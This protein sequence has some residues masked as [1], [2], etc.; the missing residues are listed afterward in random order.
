M[1][2]GVVNGYAVSN[3]IGVAAAQTIAQEFRA[4]N[5]AIATALQVASGFQ[6]Q[7][8]GIQ[9][10]QRRIAVATAP[11]V[12]AAWIMSQAAQH[13]TSVWAPALG[14]QHQL[15]T[16]FSAHIA[17]YQHAVSIVAQ[18]AQTF[19]PAA[20]LPTWLSDDFRQWLGDILRD[21]RDVADVDDFGL[22]LY[23]AALRARTA[24][25][26]DPDHRRVVELFVRKHL[27]IRRVSVYL[28]DAVCGV[29]LEDEWHES[30]MSEEALRE[31][32][33]RR[34]RQAHQ[35]A[36]PITDARL[37]GQRFVASLDKETTS[38]PAT[39]LV[40]VGQLSLRPY[41]VEDRVLDNIGSF[42]DPGL[43]WV[44]S[45][46][47]QGALTI[48]TIKAEDP[49]LTWSDAAMLAGADPDRGE[50]VRRRL[51]YLAA[52]YEPRRH[53]LA[54]VAAAERHHR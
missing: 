17:A 20:L 35:V 25:L 26:R 32:L 24:V 7:L 38:D 40:T 15:G 49:Q 22:D 16:A 11:S 27:R 14:R 30:S 45:Q 41:T 54:D 21:A 33:R 2:C 12:Q 6:A 34:A 46:L 37:R 39:G 53:A 3:S 29:L 47:D 44:A 52:Q 42:E 4:R 36:R 50:A 43:R 13:A 1:A 23:T 28:I 51:R 8:A 19:A 5:E 31:H 48:A 10:M 9:G 18:Q